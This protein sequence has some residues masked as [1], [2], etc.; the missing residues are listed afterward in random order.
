[1]SLPSLLFAWLIASLYGALYHLVRGG[2]AGRL[3]LFILLAWVGFASGQFLG[4]W[5]GWVLFPLGQVNLGLGT[6]ASLLALLS[7]DLLSRNRAKSRTS[8]DDEN[9]V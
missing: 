7:G 3:F 2:G 8:T 1:M 5:R 4:L 6:L 9:A